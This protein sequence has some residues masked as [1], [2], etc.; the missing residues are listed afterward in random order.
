MLGRWNLVCE[1]GLKD[2]TEWSF[3]G[4]TP[5]P[6]AAEHDDDGEWTKRRPNL[7][8]CTFLWERKQKALRL[9]TKKHVPSKW[10][11]ICAQIVSPIRLRA[12]VI[13]T[14]VGILNKCL[15]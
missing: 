3:L 12:F 2:V 9:D 10:T 14:D 8:V 6:G 5:Y 13:S 15:N 7:I 4:D 11:V 1:I